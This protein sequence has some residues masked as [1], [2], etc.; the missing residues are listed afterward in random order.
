[1]RKALLLAALGVLTLTGADDTHKSHSWSHFSFPGTLSRPEFT[2]LPTQASGG[3]HPG[4]N[5]PHN[6]PF[7]HSGTAPA[8]L[9]P[10]W[11]APDPASASGSL[12]SPSG[13]TPPGLASFLS[14]HTATGAP[15]VSSAATGVGE[16]DVYNGKDAVFTTIEGAVTHSWVIPTTIS[17]E[18]THTWIIPPT[19]GGEATPT[20]VSV[21]TVSNMEESHSVWNVDATLARRESDHNTEKPSF[22]PTRVE[23]SHSTWPSHFLTTGKEATTSQSARG[24]GSYGSGSHT[25]HQSHGID[26]STAE[27]PVKPPHTPQ[28]GP[29]IKTVLA[30]AGGTVSVRPVPGPVVPSTTIHHTSTHSKNHTKSHSAT[31]AYGGEQSSSSTSEEWALTE[32]SIP[33]MSVTIS[34]VLSARDDAQLATGTWNQGKSHHSQ[35]TYSGHPT[36]HHHSGSQSHTGIMSHSDHSQRTGKPTS[37]RSQPGHITDTSSESKHHTATNSLQNHATSESN[38]MT[39]Q[40]LVGKP[41]ITGNQIPPSLSNNVRAASL[42]DNLSCKKYLIGPKGTTGSVSITKECAE[43]QWACYYGILPGPESDSW[44]QQCKAGCTC[45]DSKLV[46]RDEEHESSPTHHQS[47]TNTLTTVHTLS[48]EHQSLSKS[49]MKHK[50]HP[51]KTTE[52]GTT[53]NSLDA[54]KHTPVLRSPTAGQLSCMILKTSTPGQPL[55]PSNITTECV[56]LGYYCSNDK[57]YWHQQ[58]SSSS[59]YLECRVSCDCDGSENI[60]RDVDSMADAASD[61]MSCERGIAGTHGVTGYTDITGDCANMGFQ[62]FGGGIILPLKTSGAEYNQCTAVCRC[63]DS[64]KMARD[65]ENADTLT[66]WTGP[67]RTVTTL[68][69][70]T[71]SWTLSLAAVTEAPATDLTHPH[72]RLSETPPSME[73]RSSHA[74]CPSN[75]KLVT[76]KL[77]NANATCCCPTDHP[78]FLPSDDDYVCLSTDGTIAVPYQPKEC[79]HGA[80]QRG[81]CCE[82]S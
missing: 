14:K 52:D 71:G 18:A 40:Q 2:G 57:L 36:S 56:N 80:T 46:F 23:G 42:D 6:G 1:M 8:T 81:V 54:P 75:S 30:G 7:S 19:V 28:L 10:H 3:F 22:A 37:Q 9:A 74:K 43:A 48:S 66:F 15:W 31:L 26:I 33:H 27:T 47:W 34:V 24:P 11:S 70:V 39:E 53:I 69:P 82:W 64:N 63:K 60:T 67:H 58:Q 55:V 49:Q 72:S 13:S 50:S 78:N 73:K 59:L 20:W 41:S 29:G 79:T 77:G 16:K 65:I 68:K 61:D 4:H 38:T 32:T 44:Y 51:A 25:R 12:T 76:G 35:P 5:H 21:S 62:C 45:T 17:G